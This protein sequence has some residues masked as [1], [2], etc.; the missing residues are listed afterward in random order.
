M[1][2]ALFSTISEIVPALR[3]F[4][5]NR[6]RVVTSMTS[7][8]G[9][10]KGF[11]EMKHN[12]QTSGLM[13]LVM[14]V[15]GGVVSLSSQAFGQN[16]LGDGRGLEA[17]TRL[18]SNGRNYVR[19]S[20]EKEI[21]FRNAIATGN[22][23][24]GMSFRGDLGYMAPGE[25]RG[26]L[27][28]DSLYSFRRDSLYS[29]LAGM[30][31]RGTDAIQYQFAMTTGSRV[32]SNLSGNLSM[33]RLSGSYMP[34]YRGGLATEN[35]PLAVD[36]AAALRLAQSRVS[37]TLRSTSSY[38]STSGLVPELV[39]TFNR[40]IEQNPYGLLASPLMG[41]T[42]TPMGKQQ[43]KQELLEEQKNPVKT[44]YAELVDQVRA[45]A[46]AIRKQ[47]QDEASG[48]KVDDSGLS[49]EEQRAAND[50]W[51]SQQLG[52]LHRKVLGLPEPAGEDDLIEVVQP[53]DH[54]GDSGPGPKM[55][56]PMRANVQDD[57]DSDNKT[58]KP[59]FDR[60]QG[61]L[62]DARFEIDP[63][64][65]E[66]IRGDRQRTTYLIDPNAPLR[67]I[68]SE[69]MMAGQRLLKNA[70]YF[71]AEE[72]FTTALSIRNGDVAAQLGRLHAQIGAGVVISASMNLQSLMSEHLEIISQ[73]YSGD[74]LPSQERQRELI[75][76]LRERAGLEERPSYMLPE[77]ERVRVACG[78][79]I[80]YLGFQI[81]DERQ[82]RDGFGVVLANGNESEHRLVRLLDIV[83]S[84]VMDASDDNQ[85]DNQDDSQEDLK[86]SEPK[87]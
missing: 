37:G 84:Q 85:N 74:L 64:T 59:V 34:S 24:G 49:D 31:I 14:L 7:M 10:L 67:N 28:S 42:P 81:D 18:G 51:I 66:I 32:T 60:G 75:Q 35:T 38:S 2:I 70:R 5:A 16:A 65:L 58:R 52:T 17:N 48:S 36:P 55:R 68:Y 61:L 33:S 19:P 21:E 57:D 50:N 25:F 22:A 76:T 72:R 41:L 23:P 6:E 11:L 27:G 40:G 79:L 13:A 3:G 82:M 45:R 26:S 71:D 83:W 1:G 30:G 62:G 4:G 46:E 20:L 43:T 39:T 29:G 56:D 12:R 9:G 53:G 63:K 73:R 54:D 87:P 78:L 69:H 8:T 86:S 15:G 77:T 44:S 80:A 47:T